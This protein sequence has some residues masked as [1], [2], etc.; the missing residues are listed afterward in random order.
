[1]KKKAKAKPVITE[2]ESILFQFDNLEHN[3]A[4]EANSRLRAMQ[5]FWINTIDLDGFM[6]KTGHD[7]DDSEAYSD[8]L[9]FTSE[10]F[11][12]AFGFGFTIGQ[13]FDSTDRIDSKGVKIIMEVIREKGLLPYLP[14][15]K[16]AA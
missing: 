3:G 6:K 8:F 11:A 13:K 10:A 1:M 16:K 2:C 15:E 7:P 5:N 14:R 4:F 12:L 9:T